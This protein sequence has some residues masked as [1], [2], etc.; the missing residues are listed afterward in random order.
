MSC[1]DVSKVVQLFLIKG[2][3]VNT[4]GGTY[5]EALSAA[6]CQ[7]HENAV[8]LLLEKRGQCQCSRQNILPS[9]VSSIVF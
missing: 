8:K 6:S 2:A 9:A 4:E 7:G 3:E 1:L 5:G